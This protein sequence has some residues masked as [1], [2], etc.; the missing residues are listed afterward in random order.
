MMR[1]LLFRCHFDSLP[2]IKDE[3]A[4]LELVAT[5]DGVGTSGISTGI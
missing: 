3:L 2:A 5:K 4:L 1:L